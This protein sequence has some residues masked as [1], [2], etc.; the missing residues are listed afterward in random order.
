M[1]S[2]VAS[3]QRTSCG[4]R[5]GLWG[6]WDELSNRPSISDDRAGRDGEWLA[7]VIRVLAVEVPVVDGDQGLNPAAREQDGGPEPPAEPVHVGGVIAWSATGIGTFRLA[8]IAISGSSAGRRNCR[9]PG[10]RRP[11]RALANGGF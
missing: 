2:V 7:Q 10:R 9:R 6:F 3:P 8:T 5:L 1:S 4:G 11:T